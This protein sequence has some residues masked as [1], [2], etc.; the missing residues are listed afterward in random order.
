VDEGCNVEVFSCADYVELET[1][2]GMLTLAPGGQVTHRQHWRL[3]AH[4]F[5]P[6][7]WLAIGVQAGCVSTGRS[8][9]YAS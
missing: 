1:L 7:D 8:V 3:L 6:Q 4:K 5:T 2:S 9:Q